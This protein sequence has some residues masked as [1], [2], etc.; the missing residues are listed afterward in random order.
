MKGCPPSKKSQMSSWKGVCV[1]GKGHGVGVRVRVRVDKTSIVLQCRKWCRSGE[2]RRGCGNTTEG[3]AHTAS[4]LSSYTQLAKSYSVSQG[5]IHSG[6]HLSHLWIPQV[7]INTT[8]FQ[9]SSGWCHFSCCCGLSL[10]LLFFV[11]IGCFSP[12]VNM[13]RGC[14]LNSRQ[15]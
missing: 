12:L 15:L 11:Y 2:Y 10:F 3:S 14:R 5:L 8:H 6:P 9:L 13:T 1:W 4:V 7:L